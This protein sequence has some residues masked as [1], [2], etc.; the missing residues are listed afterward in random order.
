MPTLKPGKP[1]PPLAVETLGKGI[2]TLQTQ[3]PQAFTLIVFYRGY[4]CPICNKYLRDLAGRLDDFAS[5]GVD[6]IAISGD[7][8]ERAEKS[9]QEWKLG[10][11][12]IGYGLDVEAMRTWDLY[13]SESIK[14]EEP[15]VFCEPG[16]YLIQ[17]DGVI[18][19]AILNSSP[20]ARPTG[21][22]LLESIDLIKKM[23]YPPRGSY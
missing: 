17:P 20:F 11:F 6:V 23:D 10:Q 15:A 8:A 3:S 12:P 1:A 13:V 5:R 4:H 7:T 18:Q 22:D 14:D 16:V 21:E 2:W 9:R 19:Y